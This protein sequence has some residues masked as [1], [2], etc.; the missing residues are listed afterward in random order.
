MTLSDIQAKEIVKHNPNRGS[1]LFKR[2]KHVLYKAH[3]T[4]IGSKDLIEPIRSFERKQYTESRKGMMLSNRDVVSRVMNPRNKIYTAKGGVESYSLSTPD[5]VEDFKIFL[6]QVKGRQSLKNYVKQNIQ[7]MLDYDM[8]GLVWLDLDEY[9]NPCPTFKSIMSIYDYE[10]KGRTPEYVVFELT[11][12]EAKQIGIRSLGLSV[13]LS[14]KLITPPGELQPSHVFRVVCDS[15]DRIIT[16]ENTGEPVIISEIPNPFAF[17]G[18]PGMVVSNIVAA[19]CPEDCDGYDS[20]LA[21][22]IEL[23]NLMVFKRSLYN[24]AYAKTVYPKEWMQKQPCPTCNGSKKVD[25]YVCPECKGSGILPFQQHSDV[26]IVDYATDLNKN[27]PNPPMG[28]VSPAVDALQF[29]MDNNMS[30]E[31][32]INYT[33]WGVLSVRSN[34]TKTAAGHGGNVS[35]TAYEAQQNE[36]PMFDKLLEYSLWYG[37]IMKFYADGCGTFLYENSYYDCAI[38][39]GNRFM[40]ESADATFDRLLK[41]RQGKATKSELLSLTMEYLEN[42]YQNNPLEFRKYRILAVA[43]PFYHDSIADVLTWDVPEINKLEKI[44]FDDWTATLT[45]DY[46]TT[47]PDQGL[48]PRV[49]ADLRAY[50]LTRHQMD[51]NSDTLL[52][53][54][55]GSLLNAGDNVTV[56]NVKGREHMSGKQYK[57]KSVVGRYAILD[58]EGMEVT[59]LETK[60]LQKL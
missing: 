26:V 32:T 12:K 9:G 51:N 48:E 45:D 30:L 35:N 38:L 18:V 44:Y 22:S 31:D 24:V 34:G 7:P 54:A 17:M 41:A 1:I 28:H 13:D 52:F 56:R 57:L 10:L 11:K 33:Q 58:D 50:V 27:V 40:I 25:S 14:G 46:F 5:L 23:L 47:L 2:A 8:E 16:W 53:N 29:M 4:G 3:V 42:K 60:D 21:P 20:P 6:A 19:S 15:F 59:G 49:K 36:Q 55:A 39:G 43:E 37:E